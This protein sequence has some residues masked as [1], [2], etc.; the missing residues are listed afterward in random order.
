MQYQISAL[1][2]AF[3]FLRSFFV[4][5]VPVSVLLMQRSDCIIVSD[6]QMQNCGEKIKIKPSSTSSIKPSWGSHQDDFLYVD[7]R[8]VRE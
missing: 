1:F 8:L 4:G 7:C 2:K 3:V 5:C 6:V